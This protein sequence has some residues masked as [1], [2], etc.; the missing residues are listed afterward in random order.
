MQAKKLKPKYMS[1]IVPARWFSG[2]RGLNEFRK[3]MLNDKRISKIHDFTN[4]NEVFP[5]VDIAGGICYFLWE[6]DYDG[7]CSVVSVHKGI[8][9]LSTR[10][11]NEFEIFVRNN[12]SVKIIKKIKSKAKSFLSEIILSSKPFGFRSFEKGKKNQFQ[13][14]IVMVGSG[15]NTYVNDDEITVNR[16]YIKKYKVMFSKASTDHGGQPDKEG[17]RKIFSRVEVLPINHI[18]TES[19]LVVGMYDTIEEAENM[20][21]YLKTKFCRFLVST[22]L[23]TQNISKSKFDFVPNIDM[24]HEW[25]DEKLYKKFDL[26]DD[27]IEF[28]ENM[29]KSMD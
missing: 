2:G 22:I 11:L 15:G 24:A 19:Y 23:L 5:G 7:D 14:C 16:N 4:S 6:K 29:I 27:E 13:N 28:I 25:T 10:P 21:L 3:E 20:V 1:M 8:E 9:D 12:L 18:C 17:R 26:S